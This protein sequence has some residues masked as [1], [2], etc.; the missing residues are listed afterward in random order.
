M[1]R[2]ES[3][4]TMAIGPEQLDLK[5]LAQIFILD[6]DL[7]SK[8]TVEL[9]KKIL[10]SFTFEDWDNIR[11]NIQDYSDEKREL[12]DLIK[13]CEIFLGAMSYTIA[14]RR[15]Q[16]LTAFYSKLK[17]AISIAKNVLQTQPDDPEGRIITAGATDSLRQIFM[18]V[19]FR[20]IEDDYLS[21][22]SW[23]S[24]EDYY[25]SLN[26]IPY[27]KL[28]FE[29]NLGLDLYVS[30]QDLPFGG[31]GYRVN[32]LY[33]E[34]LG[35]D[36]EGKPQQKH[37][38][39]TRENTITI[40]E[41]DINREVRLCDLGGEM[42]DVE[43]I[44]GAIFLEAGLLIISEGY[45]VDFG[46]IVASYLKRPINV[47]PVEFECGGEKMRVE[48]SFKDIL[49]KTNLII[50]NQDKGIYEVSSPGSYL[51]NLV[52]GEE[53]IA[54]VEILEY[55]KG[56]FHLSALGNYEFAAN[57]G[58]ITGQPLYI[59]NVRKI[60]SGAKREEVKELLYASN[61]LEIHVVD[62]YVQVV[63]EKDVKDYILIEDLLLVDQNAIE[64]GE[65]YFSKYRPAESGKQW[66]PTVLLGQYY[67]SPEPIDSDLRLYKENP[68]IKQVVGILD[69]ESKVLY[70]RMPE[71]LEPELFIENE[72]LDLVHPEKQYQ[73]EV[74]E[75]AYYNGHLFCD[76]IIFE[77]TKGQKRYNSLVEYIKYMDIFK[78]IDLNNYR[79]IIES[80]FNPIYVNTH[81]TNSYYW[82]GDARD[83]VY[84]PDTKE[85]CL[86]YLGISGFKSNPASE[87][88]DE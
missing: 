19:A 56:K 17:E 31:A 48:K 50:K 14:P 78:D 44:D 41:K 39:I 2:K 57:D 30:L 62:G 70:T 15:G 11:H 74:V 37:A 35:E 60:V 22:D 13:K 73:L 58:N 18:S 25:G 65:K 75:L 21:Q 8:I 71:L 6:G 47:V 84:L 59:D 4:Q 72:Y 88:K 64:V 69:E 80:K 26:W 16:F 79:L 12:R 27:K 61:G 87:P 42:E 54:E 40:K 83:I 85:E 20:C 76:P 49:E 63:G 43:I 46:P 36:E 81:R 24:N 45:K 29:P 38:I 53:K 68:E 51:L 52:H 67:I 5:K 7:E 55:N 3:D 1:Y 23:Y 10:E 34:Y 32:G 9:V 33:V 66:I 82:Q 28:R 86:V 77:G